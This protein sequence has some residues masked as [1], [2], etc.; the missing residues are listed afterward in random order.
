LP[1][2]DTMNPLLD[3]SGLPRFAQVKPADIT[4]AID[5]L[6]A[7][8]RALLARLTEDGTPATWA[9][10][11][12]PLE[13][14]NERLSRAWG[15]VGHLH[16]VLDSPEL[17]EAY[18]ENQPK[19]V[20]YWTELGQNERLF[21]KYKALQASAEFAALSG[22][23]QRIVENEIRDF[24]LSGAELPPAEKKR[25][26]EIM[27]ALAKLSTEFSENLLDAT[28]AFALYIGDA[29]SLAG[30]PDDAL[31]AA[32]EAAEKD[33]KPGWK[34]TLQAPSYL[35]VMQSTPRRSRTRAACKP[36]RGESTASRPPRTSS[37]AGT[38]PR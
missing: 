7:E 36:T 38:I 6:L 31:E 23:Q 3:F 8:N 27:E 14:A 2:I 15:T 12:E 17:R 9:G 20:Q 10:F 25:F 1:D 5:Q 19:L 30:I 29:A 32:R 11:V 24:R 28:N 4:P 26:A 21:A 22:A 16:G 13:D 35:P 33:G 18:N 37:P 34:F